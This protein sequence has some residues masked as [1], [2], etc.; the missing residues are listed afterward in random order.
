MQVGSVVA[1]RWAIEA[2]AGTGGMCSVY[3]AR[4]PAG[5]LVAVKV[6]HQRAI[7]AE[8]R[9]AR[10]VRM[11]QDLRHPAIVRYLDSGTAEDG[12]RFLVMEW[13]DGTDLEAM[14]RARSL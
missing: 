1:R 10:E 9:F 6:L 7:D 3:R 14:L 4:G 5:D 11:L 13:L 8:E 2:V 12:Q